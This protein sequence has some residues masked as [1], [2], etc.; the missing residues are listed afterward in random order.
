M[1]KKLWLYLLMAFLFLCTI[2]CDDVVVDD[3]GIS[4][5]RDATIY[6]AGQNTTVTP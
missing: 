4:T 3:T 1:K 5:E 2:A 6:E